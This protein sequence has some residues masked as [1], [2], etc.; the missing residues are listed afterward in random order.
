MERP[1]KVQVIIM[2]NRPPIFLSMIS[3]GMAGTVA[4]AL[5]HPIDTLKTR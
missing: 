5:L 4:D 2:D 1:K 3:G